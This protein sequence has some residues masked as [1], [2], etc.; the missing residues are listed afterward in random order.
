MPIAKA[1]KTGIMYHSS[2]V[3]ATVN[4]SNTIAIQRKINVSAFRRFQTALKRHRIAA[5]GSAAIRYGL[6]VWAM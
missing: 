3:C 6:S 5:K 2:F 4:T 1:G